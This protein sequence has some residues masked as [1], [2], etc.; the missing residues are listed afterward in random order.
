[1]IVTIVATG[2]EL[3]AKGNEVEKIAGDIFRNN[4]TQQ[5]KI[6]DTGLEPL[7]NKEASGEDTKKRTLTFLV[8]FRKFK[9]YCHT[10]DYFSNLCCFSVCILF[11]EF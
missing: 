9:R 1:M 5:V 4:S 8:T 7:N 6:T 2:Y 11:Y 10:N 3:R